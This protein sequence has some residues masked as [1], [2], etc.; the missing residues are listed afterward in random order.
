MQ[1]KDKDDEIEDSPLDMLLVI[2]LKGASKEVVVVMPSSATNSLIV[3]SSI[4]SS[5]ISVSG[6]RSK[7]MLITRG[8][9]SGTLSMV[10]SD[11]DGAPSVEHL[12]SSLLRDLRR[13]LS[14]SGSSC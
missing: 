11:D 8:D 14:S 10:G 4:L 1:N 9:S 6:D 13:F 7:D 2:L 5:W 12:S 3:L